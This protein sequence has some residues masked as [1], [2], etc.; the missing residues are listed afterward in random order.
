MKCLPREG[1]KDVA[2]RW[3]NEI[4]CVIQCEEVDALGPLLLHP[5]LRFCP[6]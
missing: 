6:A 5:V 3:M 1:L 4:E 2:Q